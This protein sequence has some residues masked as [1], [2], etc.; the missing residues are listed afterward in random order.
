MTLTVKNLGFRWGKDWVFRDISFSVEKGEFLSVMGPNG[1]GKTTLL[2]CLNGILSPSEG[3][4]TVGG[5]EVSSLSRREIARAMGYV[6][7][8]V[9][10]QRM[11]VFDGVLLGRRPHIGWSVSERDLVAVE[12]VLSLLGLSDFRLR[13]M[14]QISGGERQKVAVA[15]AMVQDPSVMLLDEPTAS[16]DMKN[17]MDMM[18]I[19]SKVVHCHGLAAVATVHDVNCALRYSDR[20]LFL[21]G[22]SIQALCVP[23]E[24]T[25]AVIESVYGVKADIIDHRGKPVVIPGG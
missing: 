1:V 16:L 15:R 13:F 14:D 4:I 24:V 23:S 12:S 3:T 5:K 21:R 7:Q 22:G 18:G 11:T 25:E 2:R 8:F 19:I 6:P 17:N 20:C 9:Q 10:P